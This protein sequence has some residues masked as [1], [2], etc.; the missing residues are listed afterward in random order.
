MKRI[1]SALLG[2]S[3]AALVLVAGAC[4]NNSGSGGSS[5]HPTLIPGMG[6]PTFDTFGTPL[7]S[8]STDSV[9]AP[10]PAGASNTP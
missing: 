2:A 4:G 7:A 6:G 5:D 10:S 3:L 9:G 8:G 1:H